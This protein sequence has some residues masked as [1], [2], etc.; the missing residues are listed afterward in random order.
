M[1]SSDDTRRRRLYYR[2][3]HR[4]CKET[5]VILG[6]FADT[7]LSSIPSEILDMY[8]ELLEEQ[9]LDIWNWLIGATPLKEGKYDP[10][11]PILTKNA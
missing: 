6:H 8:E 4:G 7:K 5:D 1:E 9:D 2:S 3:W 11:L 10:L